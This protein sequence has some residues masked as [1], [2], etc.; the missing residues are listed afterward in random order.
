[1]TLYIGVDFH[2][3]QQR[4]SSCNTEKGEVHQASLIHNVEQVPRFY[5]QPHFMS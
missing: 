5:E 3:H 2:P 1:M 4:V